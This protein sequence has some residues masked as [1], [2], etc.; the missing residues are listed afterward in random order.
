[1]VLIVKRTYG[2]RLTRDHA[3][4]GL[5]P[6]V[7]RL[8]CCGAVGRTPLVHK[9]GLASTFAENKRFTGTH[10][11]MHSTVPRLLDLRIVRRW[12]QYLRLGLHVAEIFG[13]PLFQ[14]FDFRV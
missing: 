10:S 11:S 2:E 4:K 5:L 9:A 7:H 6:H 1:M 14:L 8:W 3:V 12:R 13:K